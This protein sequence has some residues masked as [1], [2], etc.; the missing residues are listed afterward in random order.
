MGVVV[1]WVGFVGGRRGAKYTVGKHS[2]TLIDGGTLDEYYTFRTWKKD[3]VF[4][5]YSII[6]SAIC[7]SNVNVSVILFH[8]ICVFKCL[9]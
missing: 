5:F 4:C 9:I 7:N 8:I 3:H 2:G 6:I 1:W